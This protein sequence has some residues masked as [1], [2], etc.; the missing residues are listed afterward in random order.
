MKDSLSSQQ[1]SLIYNNSF[2]INT[3]KI[4]YRVGSE[5]VFAIGFS[6]N[7][8]LGGASLRNRFKRQVRALYWDSFIKKNKK[9][10]M[11]IAPKTINL[12]WIDIKNSFDLVE[13]KI[14]GC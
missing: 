10:P 12:R 3:P 8:R 13:K 5:K 1:F 7:K 14:H 9:I 2:I 11:I 4:T 6:I